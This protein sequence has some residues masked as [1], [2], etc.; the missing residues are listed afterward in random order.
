MT[1]SEA[2]PHWTDRDQAAWRL[3]EA[4]QETV[5]QLTP[6]QLG[7]AALYLETAQQLSLQ[8]ALHYHPRTKHPINSLTIAEILAA[9]QLVLE[10][11]AQWA[12]QY[13]PGSHLLTVGHWKR[14]SRVPSWLRAIS[15]A[16]WAVRI[17]LQP[18]Y[19]GQY[20]TTRWATQSATSQVRENVLAWFYLAFVRYLGFYLIEMNSGRLQAGATRYRDAMRQ[21][22]R[23]RTSATDDRTLRD[24]NV[25]TPT[26]DSSATTSTDVTIA[27]VG[28]VN[29]GKSSLINIL[30][31][32]HQAAVDVLPETAEVTRYVL[33]L[34]D[35]KESLTLLDTPGYGSTG[36][37]EVQ[38][39]Q[40]HAAIQQADLV[41]LVMNVT[42][43]AR[44]ADLKAVR[45]LEDWCAQQLQLK[46][47][48]I[49]AVLTHI[50]GLSPVLEWKPPYDWMRPT[51]DK[52]SSMAAAVEAV[53]PEF[54]G[55]LSATVPVCTDVQRQR[56]YG[57]HEWL[58]PAMLVLLD[59]ARACAFLRTL[60]DDLSR[61]QFDLLFRQL[62]NAGW[63]ILKACFAGK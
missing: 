13:V 29:A 26:D 12:D 11:S 20:L 63:G 34:S 51:R 54:S 10:D 45:E 7:D 56:A 14:L 41:L 27:L 57:V 44:Q 24:Q 60:H 21:Y 39:Q 19:L 47:P 15:N 50:D 9:A 4:Q 1:A 33:N 52:E 53:Q 46:C 17:V 62:G 48:A 35:A 59:D 61:G 23:R 37:T 6:E 2:A 55:R 42:N 32:D 28:Q 5:S 8:L 30:L 3:V 38:R 36:T 49:I 22:E 58:L 25:K 18:G 16:A 43:P 31:G 40:T